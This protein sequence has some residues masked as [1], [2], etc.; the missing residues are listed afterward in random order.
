MT[1]LFARSC[2]YEHVVNEIP[3]AYCE[4]INYYRYATRKKYRKFSNEIQPSFATLAFTDESRRRDKYIARVRIDNLL[5]R[6]MGESAL[7]TLQFFDQQNQLIA[8]TVT[9]SVVRNDGMWH[10]DNDDEAS[11]KIAQI[12]THEGYLIDQ[13]DLVGERAAREPYQLV[14]LESLTNIAAAREA[15]NTISF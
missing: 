3:S 4:K 15:A 2:Y 8:N 14:A 6:R 11:T 7:F 13:M 9:P 5:D 10:P 1:V 12:V